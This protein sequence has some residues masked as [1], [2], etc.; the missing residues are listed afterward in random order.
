MGMMPRFTAPE[1][2]GAHRAPQDAAGIIFDAETF[3]EAYFTRISN[4]G[5][6]YQR[7]NPPHKI[8]GYLAEVR[9]IRPSGVLL[10]VGCAF[11]GFL[12]RARAHYQCEGLDISAY[13]LAVAR[14]QVPGIVLHHESIEAFRTGRTYDVVTCFDVVEHV[15]D[16]DAALARLRALLAPAGILAIAV[17]VYDTLPGRLF[18]L[19]DRD[20]THVHRRSRG[21]WLERLDH[22]GL[23]PVV[24]KGILRA[25]LPGAFLHL[26]RPMFRWF[27]SALFVICARH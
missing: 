22:A 25:P 15:P 23:E 19:V 18:G 7:F 11:G 17:P 2:V 1:A 3:G 14:R 8:S 20:P 6:R 9:R 4:Y 26:I 16:L 27:S 10:D 12:E 5:G 21:F 13:A 24:V